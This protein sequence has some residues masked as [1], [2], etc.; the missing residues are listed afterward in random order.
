MWVSDIHICAVATFSGENCVRSL[1]QFCVCCFA[2]SRASFWFLAGGGIVCPFWIGG[3][4]GR[5]AEFFASVAGSFSQGPGVSFFVST[6]RGRGCALRV[7][8]CAKNGDAGAGKRSRIRRAR[9]LVFGRR[10]TGV[11]VDAHFEIGARGPITIVGFAY[12]SGPTTSLSYC[13]WGL[14]GHSGWRREDS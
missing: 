14:F 6:A 7:I 2:C 4:F 9:V 1:L 10:A 3:D 8:H 11:S 5:G 13:R 12:A